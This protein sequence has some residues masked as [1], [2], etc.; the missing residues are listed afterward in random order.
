M[1]DHDGQ[2]ADSVTS[3]VREA[4]R[5][6]EIF[7]IGDDRLLC[8]EWHAPSSTVVLRPS[9]PADRLHPEVIRRVVDELAGRGVARVLTA[10]L[11]EKCLEPFVAAGFELHEPLCVFRHDLG[12]GIIASRRD[13]RRGARHRDVAAVAAL[14]ERAFSEGDPVDAGGVK[15]ILSATPVCRFRVITSRAGDPV[16]YAV[17]G[18][19]GNTGYV[20]RIAVD[21]VCR[22]QGLGRTLVSDA[23]GWF[24]RRNV[25]SVLV[26]THVDNVAA[27]HLYADCGFTSTPERLAVWS[28][29]QDPTR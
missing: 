8:D 6:P 27:R 12:R 17:S 7:R 28:W 24:Q 11:D 22:R 1:G 5:A 4:M 13:T 2:R 10:A 21:P 20:Q 14:D 26:N 23:L 15:T 3:R 19:A 18:L 16:A 9:S 29:S 25:A